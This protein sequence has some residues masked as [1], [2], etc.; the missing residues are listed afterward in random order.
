MEPFIGEIRPMAIKFAPV[1]YLLCDGSELSV[2]RFQALYAII[3]TFYGGDGKNT[4][5][6]PN[7][8]GK[9][10]LGQGQLSGGDNYALAKEGGQADVTL[11]TNE[12]PTHG[13][14][15]QGASIEA[16]NKLL[17]V[18][19]PSNTY[20]S[21]AVAKPTPDS[22]SGVVGRAYSNTGANKALGV[23]TLS[24]SGGSQSHTNMM[25]SL[26]IN[27]CIAYDGIFPQRP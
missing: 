6:L 8:A 7:L 5:K 3:G 24:L 18:P 2:S 22:P 10:V 14:S 20:L 21:N 27:Y 11:T 12:I 19:T 13:H 23:N 25:P 16:V 15:S 17:K 4:F 1:G 26:V 9:V